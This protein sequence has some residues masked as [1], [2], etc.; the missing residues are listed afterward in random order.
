[1]PHDPA[2]IRNHPNY[3]KG[4]TGGP[5]LDTDLRA[6][7]EAL[8]D[9]C[10]SQNKCPTTLAP[11]KPLIYATLPYC[12]LIEDDFISLSEE[13]INTSHKFFKGWMD[14]NR[15][16]F[17]NMPLLQARIADKLADKVQLQYQG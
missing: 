3:V 16:Q 5:L 14:T 8:I 11:G 1:M 2:V 9:Y 13:D 4:R 6:I 12:M 17:Q 7:K 15:Y 10:V